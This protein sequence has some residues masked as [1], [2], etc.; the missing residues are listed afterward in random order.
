M[1]DPNP[2]QDQ[3]PTPKLIQAMQNPSIRWPIIIIGLVLLV[4]I[5]LNVLYIY[6]VT[7]Q[8]AH[9]PLYANCTPSFASQIRDSQAAFN[10]AQNQSHWSNLSNFMNTQCVDLEQDQE[11]AQLPGYPVGTTTTIANRTDPVIGR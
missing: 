3:K 11:Q 5:L 9:D 2:F 7:E 6:K 8:L 10:Y 4:L 1:T